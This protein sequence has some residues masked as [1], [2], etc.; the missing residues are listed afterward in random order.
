MDFSPDSRH[1]P[2]ARAARLIVNH[3]CHVDASARCRTRTA[4]AAFFL[5]PSLLNVATPA[6]WRPAGRRPERAGANRLGP[7]VLLRRT[8]AGA[9]LRRDS[10]GRSSPTSAGA[11]AG[12]PVRLAPRAVVFGWG[13]RRRKPGA[14]RNRYPL[15]RLRVRRWESRLISFNFR[16]RAKFCEGPS[17]VHKSP[18]MR[19]GAQVG[20]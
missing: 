18:S 5:P 7:V 6:S 10:L 16:W 11:A 8:L 9:S 4:P 19:V 15:G 2:F 17:A 1:Q 12:P 20:T 3:R 14:I 13:V